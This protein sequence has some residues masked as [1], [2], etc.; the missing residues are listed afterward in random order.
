MSNEILSPQNLRG[1]ACSQSAGPDRRQKQKQEKKN[2]V[3]VDAPANV[4]HF[5]ILDKACFISFDKE[6]IALPEVVLTH[7]QRGRFEHHMK[8]GIL[9]A[10]HKQGLL[11]DLV[12]ME[13]VR[14]QK[15]KDKQYFTHDAD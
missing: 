12:F 8:I 11:S 13:T 7:N 15:E 2:A 14:I 9:E 3:A 6:V 5:V 1:L 4:I 10:L